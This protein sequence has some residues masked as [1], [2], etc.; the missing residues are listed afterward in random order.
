[1]IKKHLM[2]LH[3]E[4]IFSGTSKAACSAWLL[5]LLFLSFPKASGQEVQSTADTTVI[6]I[7]EQI[8]YE[9]M[10]EAAEEDLVVFPEGQSFSP[11]E[12]IDSM[13]I[14][15]SKINGRYR[16]T[17]QYALTSFDTGQYFIPPQRVLIN[18]KSF[19]T[20]SIP[21]EVLGVAVDTTKQKMYP[22]KPSIEV[23]NGFSVPSWVW[24]LLALI[25]AGIAVF[26][27]VRKKKKEQEARKLPPYEQALFELKRI[28]DSHLLENRE[29]KEYYSQLSAAVRRYLDEEVYDHA[30]E[31][32]TGELISYLERERDNGKLKLEYQ[33]IAGLRSILSRADLAKFANSKP[34]VLTAREDRSS[35]EHII[36]ETKASIP[37]PTEEE[38]L[39]DLEYRE[40]VS[41]RKRRQR[42]MLTSA[43]A[44][45]VLAGTAA[46]LLSTGRTDLIFGD[47]TREML[48]GE[49][50]RSEY[51]SPPV[52]VTTPDVLVR[53]LQDSG[54]VS[55]KETFRFGSLEE[56]IFIDLNTRPAGK[57]FKLQEALEE[58]YSYLEAKGARNIITKQEEF[59]TPNGAEGLRIYG[60]M[61]LSLGAEKFVEKAYSILN[62]ALSGYQQVVVI[63]DAEEEVAEEIAQR[64]IGSV[65]LLN[66]AK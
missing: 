1:M 20:D 45:L 7:G 33:T 58:V 46:V 27:L 39:L 44:V 35:V 32:T 11:L 14:D 24:W 49:W 51:G 57:D 17:R 50:I 28:D 19:L 22:I 60:T 37:E 3:V 55:G 5:G 48:E 53:Q 2:K 34:D 52:S 61:N 66:A 47:D 30:M 15:T 62:F 63:Y 36:N 40:R 23:P 10:V 12:V 16:L 38:L 25:I 21:I 54:A 43:I 64:I 6:K 59:V 56:E 18:D 13:Q 29:I 65:E 42:I 8:T 9:M 41:R 4:R 31:S 26:L